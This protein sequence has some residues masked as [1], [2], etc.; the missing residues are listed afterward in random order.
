MLEF[1]IVH[2]QE[3]TLAKGIPLISGLAYGK[4]FAVKLHAL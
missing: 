4:V 2:V 3:C 1:V